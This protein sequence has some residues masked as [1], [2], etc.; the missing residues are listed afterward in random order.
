[1]TV[2]NINNTN[3]GVVDVPDG[4]I[5]LLYCTAVTIWE[6]RRVLRKRVTWTDKYGRAV[7]NTTHTHTHTHTHCYCDTHPTHCYVRRDKSWGGICKRPTVVI[8]GIVT[9]T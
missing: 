3:V 1:M 7:L 2:R 9:V 5:W 8:D 6:P 4:R